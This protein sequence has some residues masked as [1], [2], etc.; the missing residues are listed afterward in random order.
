V[1]HTAADVELAQHELERAALEVAMDVAQ[2]LDEFTQ[3]FRSRNYDLV[4]ADYRLPGW[5]GIEA[6]DWLIQQG[7]DVP[8]IIVSGSL[9]EEGAVECLKRGASDYVL[10]DHLARLPVVVRRALSEHGAREARAR[11]E[12]ALR[13]SEAR[14]RQLTEAAPDAIVGVDA[15]GRIVLVNSRAEELFDYAAAELVGQSVE[16]LVPERYREAH[17]QHRTRYNAAP[18]T[19]RMGDGLDLAG[20]RKNGTEFP[21][22]ISLSPVETPDGPLV[23]TVVRD[24]SERRAAGIALRESEE[25]Y[26]NLV[27]QVSDGFFV[28]DQSGVITFASRPLAAIFGVPGPEDLV[29]RRFTE[30]LTPNAGEELR[31]LFRESIEAG[32]TPDVVTTEIVRPDGTVADV[33]VKP[34]S[35]VVGG[36]VVGSRGVVRDIT[37][38]RRL[39]AQLRQ[40]QKLEAIGQLAGGVAHDFN[41]LLT[42][43]LSEAELTGDALPEGHPVSEALQ[44]IRDAGRRGAAL[45]RQLL[46]FSRRQPVE[47]TVFSFNDVV[48]EM[49]TM[50]RRLIGEDVELVTH[51]EPGLGAVKADRG[52]IEQVLLNLVVNARDAMPGGGRL[53][54]E[55]A[56]VTLDETYVRSH[57]DATAGEHA[58]LAVS[59]TGTGMSRETQAHIFEPF[60]TTKESGKGT[61][62]GL[63]TVYGIVKQSGGHIAVYSEVGHGT[64][65]KVHL[66]VVSD[67][68]EAVT[69]AATPA[70]SLKGSET[71]LLIEDDEALRRIS[72]KVLESF[73]YR[74][75]TAASGSEGL[76]LA[77]RSAFAIDILVSDVVLPGMS[78]RELAAKLARERPGL[79]VLFVS[80]YTDDAVV[81]RGLI[82][83]GMPFLQKPFELDSLA[84]KVREVLDAPGQ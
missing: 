42:V 47:S 22:E 3:L 2:T 53:A 35:I 57:H 73:G 4:L 84:R 46:T 41:N 56:N 71:V 82:E 83:P 9:G 30:F 45:T 5:T 54:I 6:L 32:T 25:R 17:V 78:G 34:T 37:E 31:A 66:P 10:K 72:G 27:D 80:G 79:R 55:T 7:R 15:E 24:V 51:V 19:R 48:A 21:A 16:L 29:G 14:F 43:I 70:A 67:A 63:A 18:Y 11:A 74:V 36:R 69:K 49:R 28:T 38:R 76:A 59:D 62:L 20:R 75:L 23:V 81:H 1:E 40:S 64:T 68:P 12:E 61:G 44:A 13:A 65:F 52:Q 26:R 50:L 39:E 8:F 58:L 33:E 60:F 77:E